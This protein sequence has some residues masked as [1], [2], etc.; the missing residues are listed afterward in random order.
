MS[1]LYD[2]TSALSAVENADNPD[3][4]YEANEA[5]YAAAKAHADNERRTAEAQYRQRIW[6]ASPE[7]QA[8]KADRIAN[9]LCVIETQARCITHDVK[10]DFGHYLS[11]S[12]SHSAQGI[13]TND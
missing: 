3:A 6:A 8:I 7:Q 2:L 9:G 13:A 4:L 5:L 12:P 1:S 10:A 11:V